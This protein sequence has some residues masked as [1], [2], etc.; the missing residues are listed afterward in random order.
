MKPAVWRTVSLALIVAAIAFALYQPALRQNDDFGITS[1]NVPHAHAGDI[2]V[3]RVEPHSAAARA[4]IRSG[5]RLSFGETA[6]QRA[7][8]LY[9]LPGTRVSLTVNG[10]R[11]VVLTAQAMPPVGDWRTTIVRLAFLLVAALLAWRRP[12][13]RATRW[14][15]FFLWCYGL[16]I[17]LGNGLLPSPI[18]TLVFL[19]MLDGVL[20]FLG[21]GAAAGFAANFPVAARTGVS[22]S[23]ARLAQ[24]IAVCAACALAIG[25]WLP[26]S[27]AAVSLINA[28]IIAAFALIG[29]L[30]VATF[31]VTYVQGAPTERQR[32]RWVFIIVGFGL[33]GPLVDILVQ[34]TLGYQQWVDDLALIPLALLPIGLAYVILRHRVIDVGFVLNRAVVY[35]G[36]SV[37][38]V[39]AFMIAETL[40]GK[41]VEST[42]HITSLSLE[43]AVAL[44]LGFSIR[45]VHERVDRFVDTALF[46]ERHLAEAAI[47]NFAHDAP[48]ITD[49]DVLLSRA[50]A[51]VERYANAHGAGIWVAQNGTYRPQAT[52][53]ALAPTVDE[54]DPAAVAMR[55]RRVSV[56][57]RD[58]ESALPGFLGFPMIV[59]AELVGIL[60]CGPK[61]DDE[62]YAPD[63]Q[64]AL[65]SL[66]SSV[67]HALD[68]IEIRDLRRRLETLTATGGGQPAF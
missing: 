9:A 60:V 53:F 62:T 48:Y 2:I 36:V 35:T 51:T 39:G 31:V 63:E 18:L 38:V 59:R 21:T 64:D 23:M 55:A 32:R 46:R 44:A 11:R 16:A 50:V 26:R 22:R 52:T 8:T 42:S 67:G 12:E 5:D 17:G 65:A 30:V 24:T 7:Q 19:K 20:F 66:A 1:F 37:I 58:C 25:E 33:L 43:V 29:L 10:S 47:R 68:A 54:N 56:H 15:V 40:V 45:Y 6:A 3:G 28:G 13:D 27:G 49:A 4:G 34:S 14:L 61:L 41:Y 57:L